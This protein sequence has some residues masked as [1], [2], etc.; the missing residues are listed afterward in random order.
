MRVAWLW[1]SVA[2]WVSLGCGNAERGHGSEATAGASAGGSAG[3][4]TGGAGVAPVA[5]ADQGPAGGTG[6]GTS[7]SGTGGATGGASSG[8]T[9]NGSITVQA[10]LFIAHPRHVT[11]NANFPLVTGSEADCTDSQFG[12]CSLSHCAFAPSTD[13][14]QHVGTV[15]LDGPEAGVHVVSVPDDTGHYLE[16]ENSMGSFSGG[17]ALAV[18][19]S[20][21]TLPGFT[22]NGQFPLLLLVSQP[23]T[24]AGTLG[25]ALATL[26]RTAPITLTWTRGVPNVYFR[27]QPLSPII[28][29]DG[30][31]TNFSCAFDSMAGTGSIDSALLSQIPAGTKLLLLT[32][33]E[34]V[35]GNT[36]VYVVTEAMTPDK[37][38]S[39]QIVLQ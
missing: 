2:A 5:G 35:G 30:S 1:C 11:I 33:W 27:V 16:S 25:V 31:Y 34:G 9:R 19:A 38:A 3:S 37:N 17:E 13:P 39:V 12:E 20:G 36:G 29:A 28:E 10:F 23:V 14:R 32:T 7:G 26:P 18:T 6:Q 8:G 15:T 24:A 4:S 22:L 21:G